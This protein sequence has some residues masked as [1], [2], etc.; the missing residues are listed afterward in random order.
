MWQNKN[1]PRGYIRIVADAGLGKTALAAE[2]AR[3]YRAPAFFASASSGL[4]RPDQCL[5]HLSA[6]LISPFALKHDHLP[7]RAG[8]EAL[9]IAR[10]IAPAHLRAKALVGLAPYLSASCCARH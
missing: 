6:E 1:H 7:S 5:N 10:E 9:V 4:T 8:E 3:R 2:I